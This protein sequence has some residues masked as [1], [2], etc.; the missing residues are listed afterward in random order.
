MLSIGESATAKISA[1]EK[2][3]DTGIHLV[4]DQEYRFTATGQWID[5]TIACDAN[6]YPSPHWV[7]KISERW[8]RVTNENWFALIGAINF[9][10]RNFF[11]I[12]EERTLVMS[13]SGTLTCFANDVPFMYWNNQGCVQLTVTR[14]Q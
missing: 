9:N 1:I 6:G 8:R 2:W 3:N 7:L 5:W 10:E 13:E 11:A 12:G 14:V 4:A